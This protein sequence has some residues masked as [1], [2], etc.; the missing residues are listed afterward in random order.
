M[1]VTASPEVE[2]ISFGDQFVDRDGK[3]DETSTS[4]VKNLFEFGLSNLGNANTRIDK[5]LG[6]MRIV[7]DKNDIRKDK[8]ILSIS[9]LSL[10][11]NGTVTKLQKEID[12]KLVH[13]QDQLNKKKYGNCY[14]APTHSKYYTDGAPK[15]SAI[16]PEKR[17]LAI[18]KILPFEEDLVSALM[19]GIDSTTI[20]HTHQVGNNNSKLATFYLDVLK[21]SPSMKN[22]SG[23][24][25][26]GVDRQDVETWVTYLSNLLE[27]ADAN[28][29]AS[30][31]SAWSGKSVSFP[32]DVY[33]FMMTEFNGDHVNKIYTWLLNGVVLS[34]GM[35]D[36]HSAWWKLLFPD[37]PIPQNLMNKQECNDL[38]ARLTYGEHQQ[39]IFSTVLQFLN[40]C[41]NS[42]G[43]EYMSVGIRFLHCAESNALQFARDKSL[44]LGSETVY[45]ASA[46]IV[47]VQNGVAGNLRELIDEPPC[48]LCQVLFKPMILYDM[49]QC[50]LCTSVNADATKEG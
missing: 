31:S 50:Q 22:S 27:C 14:I 28:I 4:I 5:T 24:L 30:L 17:E 16:P 21:K 19:D 41:W 32:H 10:Q 1:S 35:T 44:L 38:I 6:V 40:L 36:S 47:K 26:C 29:S 3:R 9:G 34:Q 45:W 8:Y 2:F 33:T 48:D 11:F 20:A 46:K 42:D 23:L 43:L 39:F 18:K 25:K 15:A 7:Y 12:Q 37:I 13:W 49:G